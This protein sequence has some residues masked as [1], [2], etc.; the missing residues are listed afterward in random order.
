VNP[1]EQYNCVITVTVA[2][3]QTSATNVEV[4]DGATAGAKFVAVSATGGATCQAPAVGSEGNSIRCTFPSIAPATSQTMTVTF[5]AAAGSPCKLA[6]TDTATINDAP[7]NDTNDTSTFTTNVDCEQPSPQMPQCTIDY[8]NSPVGVAIRGTDGPDVIC[9]S[10]FAD[11]I[12]GMGG[13]DIIFGNGG[14]DAI[15]GNA[16]NDTIFGGSGDDSIAGNEGN[17]TMFG[18]DGNDSINGLPGYD[19]ANGG[20]GQDS[21]TSAVNTDCESGQTFATSPPP[22]NT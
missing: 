8:R 10:P 6:I 1:G 4:T 9:G 19:T 7:T 20:A 14:N 5:R 21:C 12:Q 17:D 15:Q 22:S 13:D 18:N 16:G 2:G 11:S 3:G